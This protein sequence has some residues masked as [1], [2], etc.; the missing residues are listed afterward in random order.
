MKKERKIY[1]DEHESRHN[2]MVSVRQNQIHRNARTAQKCSSKC[3]YD[4]AQLQY[5]IQHRT[6]PASVELPL[7]L[8]Y[9]QT[10]IPLFL[11]CQLPV[12]SV[13]AL[14]LVTEPAQFL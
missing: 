12:D 2:E 4:C 7:R 8:S 9:P 1:T 14:L 13:H 5:T 11:L 3:A 10:S 6:V